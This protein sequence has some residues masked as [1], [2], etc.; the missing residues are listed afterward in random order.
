[1]DSESAFA[2]KRD[3]HFRIRISKSLNLAAGMLLSSLP[4]TFWI[5]SAPDL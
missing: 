4:Q 5:A 2:I 3:G 1:M